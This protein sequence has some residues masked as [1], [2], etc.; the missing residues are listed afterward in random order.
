MLFFGTRSKKIKKGRL[1]NT[2]CVNCD[3]NT[4]MTYTVFVKYFHVY[5]VPVFPFRKKTTIECNDC[6][7]TYEYKEL[8]ESVKIKFDRERERNPVSFPVWMFS[9]LIVLTLLISW[10]FYQSGNADTREAGYIK[11]PKK[12]DVYFTNPEPSV[13][14]SLRI[15]KVDKDSVYFT[16]NDTFATKYIRVFG[17]NEDKNYSTKKGTYSLAKVKQLFENDSIFSIKR[18]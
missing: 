2:T 14:S 16:L 7:Y 17:I 4:S 8:P 3:G 15:D 6:Y 9:G 1:S 5:W 10:A 13:Y 11:N 12:G 18:E